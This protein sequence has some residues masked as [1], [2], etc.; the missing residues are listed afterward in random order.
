MIEISAFSTL[1]GYQQQK[2]HLLSVAEQLLTI[3]KTL[4]TAELHRALQH[5]V[6]S[7]RS[8]RLS[9]LILGK[10]GSGKTTVINAFLGQKVLPA[11]PIPE[12]ALPIEIT[13]GQCPMA[14]IHYRRA[15]NGMRRSPQELTLIELE[16]GLFRNP[17]N[18]PMDSYERVEILL[19]HPLLDS[20]VTLIDIPG[21]VIPPH[22]G[23]E[24][25]LLLQ[26]GRYLES[27]TA[28]VYVQDSRAQPTKDEDLMIQWIRR[29]GHEVIFFLCNHM[30]LII[31]Q[32]RMQVKLRNLARLYPFTNHSDQYIFFVDAQTAMAGHFNA[33]PA[34]IALSNL[35]QAG[36]VLANFLAAQ[37]QELLQHIQVAMQDTILTAL[38]LLEQ[39]K[40]VLG[41]VTGKLESSR[42]RDY[43]L[44]GYRWLEQLRS[45]NLASVIR[46]R[47]K[48][49]EKIRAL[50][51]SFYTSMADLIDEW[52]QDYSHEPAQQSLYSFVGNL[53]DQM[54][55]ELI[56]F[57]TERL[58]EESRLWL[59]F[60]W[61]PLLQMELHNIVKLLDQP[62]RQFIATRNEL[63]RT[64]TGHANQP[65]TK[66][67][68]DTSELSMWQITLK[69]M[70]REI[71][72]AIITHLERH[73]DSMWSIPALV[74]YLFGRIKAEIAR[75]SVDD[76][77][78]VRQI[79]AQSYRDVL[80]LIYEY[81]VHDLI[82]T[83][84]TMLY[85]EQAHIEAQLHL[86]EEGL[87]DAILAQIEAWSYIDT[88][89][90][91]QVIKSLEHAIALLWIMHD[92]IGKHE[93]YPADASQ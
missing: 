10:T 56:V 75:I 25:P 18:E 87:Q 26:V 30:H 76:E 40:Q 17:E 53:N 60:D 11:Y 52:M 58:R 33:Q 46:A 36:N 93:E 47:V 2:C 51:T 79:V 74:T 55:K 35:A 19:P 43:Y 48:L 83:I 41:A 14:R 49:R 54:I 89:K 31:P 61:H 22:E 71:P 63:I 73:L 66:E 42:L 88:E 9:I 65:R 78:Q 70:E 34:Q 4:H 5:L 39:K 16:T 27:A 91:E 15:S 21:C 86:F 20:G 59:M 69:R 38:H 82:E 12:L 45:L 80:L 37:G 68:A 24:T 77:Q 92:E 23:N 81:S 44:D 29:A 64:L 67:E 8:S 85:C 32:Q 62:L 7:L 50:V 1:H 13:W 28:I 90:Y 84:D 3:V 6:D 57:L 72:K